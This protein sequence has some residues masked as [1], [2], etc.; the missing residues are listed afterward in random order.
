M[1]IHLCSH[2]HTRLRQIRTSRTTGRRRRPQWSGGCCAGTGTWWE[3]Q[4][5]DLYLKVC[6]L[7][8]DLMSIT[9]QAIASTQ[10]YYLL[11]PRLRAITHIGACAACSRVASTPPAHPLCKY[12]RLLTCKLTPICAVRA[13]GWAGHRDTQ[14]C[15]VTHSRVHGTR[16]WHSC[17]LACALLCT[18]GSYKCSP[19]GRRELR[20]VQRGEE[21]IVEP[22]VPGGL[23]FRV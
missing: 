21:V 7:V 11:P 17:I 9:F 2:V 15:P 5:S 8:C 6:C 4:L 20:A 16:K 19:H 13:A 14:S 18:R 3:R 22:Q 10:A 23:G 12:L 1:H